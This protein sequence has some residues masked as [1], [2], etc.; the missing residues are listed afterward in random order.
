M[1]GHR[2]DC[3]ECSAHFEQ[4]LSAERD[5]AAAMAVPVPPGLADRALELAARPRPRLSGRLLAA[6][7]VLLGIGWWIASPRATESM[8]EATVAHVLAEP[9]ET[10]AKGPVP[11]ARVAEVLRSVGARLEGPLEG[12]VYAGTCGIGG[13]QGAHLVLEGPHGAATV[14]VLPAT[15][16]PERSFEASGY[17]GRIL[18]AGSGSLA[19]LS[20]QPADLQR[21]EQALGG[22]VVVGPG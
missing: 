15:R 8:E 9:E 19:L 4:V 13:Q 5:L 20:R 11:A 12:V 14:L 18:P 10:L 7:L 21:L 22:R 2:R 1:R 3:L 6:A 17:S 16:S